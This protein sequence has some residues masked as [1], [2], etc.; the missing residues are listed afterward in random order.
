MVQHSVNNDFRRIYSL[1]NMALSSDQFCHVVRQKNL[2]DNYASLKNREDY[3]EFV[4]IYG[5]RRTNPAFWQAADWFHEKY[6]L[7]QP[8]L[9]GLFDLNRYQNR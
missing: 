9:S 6:S 7:D 8:V 3:E 2:S 1:T 4:S 5:I